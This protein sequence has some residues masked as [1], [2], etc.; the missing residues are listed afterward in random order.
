MPSADTGL[1][2]LSQEIPYNGILTSVKACGYVVDREAT[3]TDNKTKVFFQ[4]TAYRLEGDNYIQIHDPYYIGFSIKGNETFG[5]GNMSFQVTDPKKKFEPWLL[6]KG[7][8][9][10][11]IIEPGD[12]CSGSQCPLHVNMIDPGTNC[13]QAFYYNRTTKTTTDTLEA[14]DG[15]PDDIFINL[16]VTIGK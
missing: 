14:Q 8:M 11:V 16:N 2:L 9:I 7:D 1:Y 3:D 10:G 6:S 12:D 13:S 4:V 5:C 15:I